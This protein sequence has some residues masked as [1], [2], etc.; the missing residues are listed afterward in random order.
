MS[1]RFNPSRGGHAPGHLRGFFWG[2]LDLDGREIEY[3][4]PHRLPEG[5]DPLAWVAGQLHNC[6]D[7]M[8]RE[9]RDEHFDGT[10][11]C[12]SYAAGARHVLRELSR[13]AS[14]LSLRRDARIRLCADVRSTIAGALAHT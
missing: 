9:G 11:R 1:Y 2:L 13:A 10:L 12:L 4:W 6:T 3:N 14:P 5:V 8:P 7:A